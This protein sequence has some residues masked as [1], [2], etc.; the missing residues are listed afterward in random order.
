MLRKR[1]IGHVNVWHFLLCGVLGVG[2]VFCSKEH[3]APVAFHQTLLD[4]PSDLEAVKVGRRIRLG[5][6]MVDPTNVAGYVVSL[7]DT[8]GLLRESLLTGTA[9]TYT[10]EEA[11]LTAEVFVDSTWFF[12]QVSA[13]DDSLFR[14]PAA[15]LDT[16][17]VFL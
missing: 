12:F 15:R 2:A 14:G 4:T 13:V 6:D 1:Q 16:V 7:S 5:W 8:T 10:I 9:T 17:F 3:E 11:S